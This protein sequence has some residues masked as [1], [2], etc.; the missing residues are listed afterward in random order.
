MTT[1][2]IELRY[3]RAAK[4]KFYRRHHDWLKSNLAFKRYIEN[5]R[6][7]LKQRGLL[8]DLPSTVVVEEGG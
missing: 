4:S 6:R 5:R 3:I 2:G 7:A 8:S 1:A